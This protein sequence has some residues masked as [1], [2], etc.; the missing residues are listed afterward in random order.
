MNE[1]LLTIR[2]VGEILQLKVGAI[3]NYTYKGKIGFLK[4]PGGAI[5]FTQ[6][7][8]NEFL[9]KSKINK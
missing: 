7:H 3:R 4:L 6:E 9:E 1:K 5:R 2:D 8:V